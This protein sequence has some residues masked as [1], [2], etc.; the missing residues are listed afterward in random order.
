MVV[1]ARCAVAHVS[2]SLG[3]VSSSEVDVEVGGC[4]SR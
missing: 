1:R 2:R 4:S 3:A